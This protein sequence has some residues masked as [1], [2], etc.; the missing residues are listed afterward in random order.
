MLF[1]RLP[2]LEHTFKKGAHDWGYAAFV[3][4]KDLHDP[5]KG[6]LVD[7]SFKIRATVQVLKEHS[8]LFNCTET[9]VQVGHTFAD[10]TEA[11]HVTKLVR[12]FCMTC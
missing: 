3:S 12:G 5:A 1:F 11:W 6:F 10:P 8:M 2:D 9:A 7:G 4:L